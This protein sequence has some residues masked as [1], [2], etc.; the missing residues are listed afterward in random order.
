MLRLSVSGED[1]DLFPDETI[2]LEEESPVFEIDSIPGGFS[3]PFSIP[4]TPRNRRILGFPERIEKAE[5]MTVEQSFTLYHSGIL[6]SSGTLSVTEAGV[7][8]KAHLKVEMGDLASKIKNLYLKNVFLGGERTWEWKAE[9]KHPQDDFCL[10]PMWNTTFF[11][12]TEWETL[13]AS[14]GHKINAYA[15]GAFLHNAGEVYAI[16]PFPF[17]SYVV[18]QIFATYGFRIAE[19][20]L[21]TD[22]DF[23]DLVLY[24]T[25]DI[26]TG[27]VTFSTV[28]YTVG[29]G[30]RGTTNITTEVAT[31]DRALTTFN[32]QDCMP[33]MLISE[34]LKS[35]R[36]LLN[37]AYVI[38]GD[39]VRIIKRKDL[40]HK[41]TAIDLT[42]QVT[43]SPEVH[44]IDTDGAKLEWTIDDADENWGEDY[45]KKIE[46]YLTCVKDPLDTLDDLET[47][48]PE[49]N[50]IRYIKSEDLFYR[51]VNFEYEEGLF[52]YQWVSWSYNFQNEII[53][54][55]QDVFISLIA[56]IID[57]Y[58]FLWG[59]AG[60]D[61]YKR[62]PWAEQPGRFNEELTPAP[63]TPR[64]LFYRGMIQ[65]SLGDEY[66]FCIHDNL[67]RAGTSVLPGKNLTLSFQGDYGLYQQL[68][69]DYLT[70]W[71]SRKQVNWTIKDPSILKFN[72]KYA[73]D[74]KHYLLKKRTVNLGAYS[75]FPGDCEF[76]LV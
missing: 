52:R 25:R 4:I 41:P 37:L 73:I 39:E 51:F 70:W 56:P 16:V 36:N 21:L 35:I 31:V 64:L 7:E 5:P 76:Y 46:D 60:V 63:Y 22:P 14:A 54:N 40:V 74:G 3:F 49:V 57:A 44:S 38:R 26:Q 67:D 53:G 1:L 28:T 2:T 75:I 72:E 32:L 43:G 20:V 58:S 47:L 30:R 68:W 12:D 61:G 69:K 13:F 23:R 8:Y 15:A 24:S 59:T 71:L 9:Y 65:D 6:R 27:T 62:V 42:D 29:R 18:R 45:F 10:A 48:T 50:E 55:G 11:K 19:N 34:F 66:P 17:L 33:D